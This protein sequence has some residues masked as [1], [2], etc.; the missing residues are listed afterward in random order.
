MAPKDEEKKR[1]SIGKLAKKHKHDTILHF[2]QR[3][4]IGNDIDDDVASVNVHLTQSVLPFI[5]AN[6]STANFRQHSDDDFSSGSETEQE[7]APSHSSK[8]D[9]ATDSDQNADTEMLQNKEKTIQSV[10]FQS[11]RSKSEQRHHK[12]SDSR[13]LKSLPK[14]SI[15]SPRD[16]NYLSQSMIFPPRRNSSP[17]TPHGITPRDAPVLSQIL[18][19]QAQMAE[20]DDEKK[21]DGA[22]LSVEEK[23]EEKKPVSLEEALMKIFDLAEEEEVLAEYSC[24]LMQSVLLQGYLYITS[25]HICY[26]AYLP[27][28]SDN[29]AKSGHLSKKGKS[30]PRYSRY[31]VV[32]QGDV[33]SYYTDPKERYF[34]SGT[35]DLRSSISAALDKSKDALSFT[36]TTHTR[37]YHFKAD[38]AASAKEWVKTLQKVIFRSHNDGDS[39]KICLPLENVLDIEESPVLEWADTFKIRV[40]DSDETYAV[41]EYYFTFFSFGKD[42]SEVLKSL[43]D[44]LSPPK[45]SANAPTTELV[46]SAQSDKA[47]SLPDSAR[48]PLSDTVKATL[49]PGIHSP[50]IP[51]PGIP[52]P[53]GPSSA[54]A[55]G[56]WSRK[57]FDSR[58]SID[59]SRE[60]DK[61]S[62]DR[63]KIFEHKGK[64]NSS[65]GR[66]GTTSTTLDSRRSEE[67]SDSF[68]KSL[69]QSAAS[70]TGSTP[71]DT[72]AS[73][74]LSRSD[75]FRSPTISRF[76]VSPDRATS[77]DSLNHEADSRRDKVIVSPS[78][79][80]EDKQLCVARN[81][82]ITPRSSAELSP[83]QLSTTTSSLQQ[84]IKNPISQKAAGLA[85]FLR[86]KS[87]KVGSIISSES[88]NYMGK[89]SGM[90]IGGRKHYG[91][92]QPTLGEDDEDIN[93]PDE[94]EIHATRFREHF[95]LPPSEKLQAT[96]FGRLFRTLPLYGKVYIGDRHFCY[97][98]LIPGTRTKLIL[99]LAHIENVT[100]ERGFTS[101]Q[102]ALVVKIQGFEEIFFEFS[103]ADIRDD[104]AITLLHGLES[105]KQWQGAGE[106][107]SPDD[108]FDAEIAKEE[109]KLLLE[110]RSGAD[111][112]HF[113]LPKASDGEARDTIDTTP[114]TFDDPRVSIL[115]FKPTESLR[116]TCL[117]IG[118]RG[119]VQP[120]IALAKGLIAEGHRVRIAT[121]AEFEPWIQEHGI[122]FAVVD[123]NPAELMRICVE[124]GMFT[125]SFMK[126]AAS[127]F[128]GWI[129]DLLRS[130]W[131]ACQDTDLLIE[132]PSA[133][134]GI[135]IA[136]A[137]EIPYFRAFGMPWTRTRAYPHAFAVPNKRRGGAYNQLSYVLFDALFWTGISSQVNRWR[138]NTLKLPQTTFERLHANKV[139]FLYNFSPSV[140]PPPLDYSDWV[141]VTGYWFLD[142]GKEWTPPAELSA[143]IKKAR[144]DDKKLV[145]IGFGSIVVSDP[146]ALTKAVVDSVLKADVRC[147]LSKGWSDRLGGADVSKPEI[148]LPDD[149]L[150]IKSA[151]HDW[152]FQQIDAAVHHG[153]AGT[154]GASL[155]AGI[156]TIIKPFFG[157]Q[158]FFG[159]RVEDL[160]VG[161]CMRKMNVS[162]FSRALWE[163]T[164]SE[165][166]IGKAKAL[167]EQIRQV[168]RSN[169]CQIASTNLTTG[170]RSTHGHSSHISRYGICQN[171]HQ[172]QEP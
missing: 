157:D 11:S 51:S 112:A 8:P 3:L 169:P 75:V 125:V 7:K 90:W 154:T 99:P 132:S 63:G 117:T 2:P 123:G 138:K 16:K 54:R 110:A 156:P 153:G 135:H 57:S 144:D 23:P 140:V 41:D 60:L 97:R 142:E 21:L 149:I 20:L 77:Q 170:R 106:T 22:I 42:A 82:H 168:G 26:F 160:R 55:S 67:F 39:V 45:P 158:F 151:P 114:I 150:Q 52:S 68:V 91:D 32:L 146:A 74:I 98:S 34:P 64:R 62:F 81:P 73:Q 66:A 111:E 12:R 167:G 33:L 80:P 129:D 145:Y 56:E 48:H 31:W 58:R 104:C 40:V 49:S 18:E 83:A 14:L 120:Y 24:W 37:A 141:R 28:K 47:G 79:K 89:V 166:M 70:D 35:V 61:V 78:S 101:L 163:A 134:A 93:D 105:I 136:E 124:H 161:I 133:M 27:K 107:L 30:N 4:E 9:A 143:F 171:S 109:H 115:N 95:S 84:L 119:D 162:L 130:A 88:L 10:S 53:G 5:T 118:S 102:Y 19:A 76:S 44:D 147:I 126:E 72:S 65:V 159:N 15:R 172:T 86:R 165:R 17:A 46:Y 50:G 128:R 71:D 87:G 155:R 103:S 25:K 131:E 113:T 43:I 69:D 1:K 38:S 127:K 96:Y 6:S 36:V 108:V 137:L 59:I 94:D 152:L 92:A 85:G 148:P 164:H 116:I 122:D 139:P 100:K 121:H 13:L 29:I